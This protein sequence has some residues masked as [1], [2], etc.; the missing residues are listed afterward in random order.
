MQALTYWPE[1]RQLDGFN[2]VEFV[3]KNNM[4][5]QNLRED[6][7]IPSVSTCLY[8]TPR[9]IIRNMSQAFSGVVITGDRSWG[10]VPVASPSSQKLTLHSM[11]EIFGSVKYFLTHTQ[12]T[13]YLIIPPT[14]QSSGVWVP[15][16]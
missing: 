8:S 4:E 5:A 9:H 13:L 3:N 15:L 6:K 1:Q 2:Q 7:S 14:M 12:Y 11:S 16:I 10:R